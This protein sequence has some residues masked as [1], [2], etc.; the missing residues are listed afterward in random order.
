MFLVALQAFKRPVVVCP[1]CSRGDITDGLCIA[2]AAVSSSAT[3]TWQEKC[4][5]AV[6][7]CCA[8]NLKVTAERRM[9]EE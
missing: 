2:F 4:A 1:E 5:I 8:Q 3:L 9:L 6:G 7:P